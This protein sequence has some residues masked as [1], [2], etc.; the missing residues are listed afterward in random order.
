MDEL[1]L[2]TNLESIKSVTGKS[3]AGLSGKTTGFPLVGG[4]VEKLVGNT[5]R[6]GETICLLK[7]KE[8]PDGDEQFTGNSNNSLVT[9]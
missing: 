8:I 7:G 5:L 4:V 2:L 3:D 9:T 6:I 1:Q